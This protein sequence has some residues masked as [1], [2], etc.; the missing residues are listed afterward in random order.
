MI[1]VETIQPN[2]IINERM[3]PTRRL[4]FFSTAAPY[5][6]ISEHRFAPDKEEQSQHSGYS[7]VKD[8]RDY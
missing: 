3:V 2:P 8:I 6:R 4:P 5:D 1:K 7:Q